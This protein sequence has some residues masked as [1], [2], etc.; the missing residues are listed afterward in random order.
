MVRVWY[1]AEVALSVFSDRRFYRL[2]V[3]ICMGWLSLFF[4]SIF[5]RPI[6]LLMEM[7]CCGWSWFPTSVVLVGMVKTDRGGLILAWTWAK[8]SPTWSGLAG[9]I[10]SHDNDS[11]PL[12][13]EIACLSLRGQDIHRVIMMGHLM[14]RSVP[15][16]TLVSAEKFC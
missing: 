6:V 1:N 4:F 14:L 16:H 3:I 5:L 10:P 8:F 12:N 13:P 2:K 15:I 7:E 11:G 9:K